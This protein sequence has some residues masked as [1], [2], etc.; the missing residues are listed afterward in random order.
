MPSRSQAD[1][2]VAIVLALVLI[3]II[4]AVMLIPTL[5]AG[6]QS[7]RGAS[8]VAAV[9]TPTAS[10]AL[11]RARAVLARARADVIPREGL[12]TDY[13]VTFSE[14]GYRTLIQWNAEW[15][16][17][18]RTANAFESLNLMLPCC[19][20]SKPSRDEKTNCACGHHQ[21][22][23]GL[24]KKLL[25]ED[26]SAGAVQREVTRWSRYLYP[27]EALSAEM[28]KRAQLDPETKA[29][30]AELQARGEC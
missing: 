1:A 22:L 14:A 13:G 12:G 27:K 21:A 19:D 18:A 8:Q 9:V 28:V 24:S 30:L 20:W 17:E 6:F 29:A 16:V 4:S 2:G 10:A 23:E 3:A 11:E 5:L 7:E 25:S 15:Q 26:R